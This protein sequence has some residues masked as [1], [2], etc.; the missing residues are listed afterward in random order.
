M[1]ERVRRTLR[2][3]PLPVVLL[4]TMVIIGLGI[5]LTRFGAFDLAVKAPLLVLLGGYFAVSTRR[6]R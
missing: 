1:Y 6:P 2:W 3:R 4:T 5:E